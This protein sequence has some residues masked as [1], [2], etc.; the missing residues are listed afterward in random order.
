MNMSMN[1]PIALSSTE[2]TR[3]PQVKNA[4]M[5]SPGLGNQNMNMST[6]E[7]IAL[8]STQGTRGRQVKNATVEVPRPWELKYEHV[9]GQTHSAE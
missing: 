3:S 2:G 9:H 7:P 4:T 6:D 5:R 1:K 8:S